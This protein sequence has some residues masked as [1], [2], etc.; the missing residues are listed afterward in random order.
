MPVYNEEKTVIKILQKVSKLKF[1]NR[2]EKEIIVV[3]DASKDKSKELVNEY[4]RKDRDTKIVLLENRKNLGKSQTVKKG[5][6]ESTGDLVVTQDADLEYDP[7]DLIKFTKIF[8]SNPYIDVI[9]GNRFNRKNNFNSSI[10]SLGN[11]FVTYLS[12]LFTRDNGFAPKDMETCYKMIRGDISRGLFR[13]LEST[14]NF[15]LEPEITAK[16]SRYR[17]LNPKVY[18]M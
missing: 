3:D 8:L 15:G 4:I 12:N 9:Y 5:V 13:S 7:K 2:I 14:S 10:H 18:I 17:K 16:L 11:R 6:L 1:P